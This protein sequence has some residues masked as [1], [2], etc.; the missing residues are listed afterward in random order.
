M[1]SLAIGNLVSVKAVKEGHGTHGGGD[2]HAVAE[3][4]EEEG[5][6]LDVHDASRMGL[7]QVLHLLR[8]GVLADG[9]VKTALTLIEV[10]SGHGVAADNLNSGL[11]PAR[12]NHIAQSLIE[13]GA[14]HNLLAKDHRAVVRLEKRVDGGVGESDR[15]GLAPDSTACA[16]ANVANIGD[17]GIVE[18]LGDLVE[19]D[20]DGGHTHTVVN[21]KDGASLEHGVAVVVARQI[22]QV[23]AHGQ[24]V[25]NLLGN[26]VRK[27]VHAL[28]TAAHDHNLDITEFLG[29]VVLA[30]ET[31]VV[32]EVRVQ[33]LEVGVF[34]VNLLTTAE[35]GLGL[36]VEIVCGHYVLKG[37]NTRI[38]ANKEKWGEGQK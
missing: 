15:A 25:A 31:D 19:K 36:A 23:C 30:A 3:G 10:I 16:H 29:E 11:V 20:G 13:L 9:T 1:D 32:K 17:T 27:L 37:E 5:L 18:E 28:A 7:V 21:V 38:C 34:Q 24:L 12:L 33:A 22:N 2:T 14:H 35:K 8:L 4:T 26:L 6:H